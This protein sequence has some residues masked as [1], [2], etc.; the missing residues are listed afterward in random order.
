MVIPTMSRLRIGCSGWMYDDWRG[1]LYPDGRRRSGAGSSPTRSR[2]DTVEVNST[3]YRLAKRD[4]VAFW[5]NRTPEGFTF[6]VKASRYL[7]AY[8]TAGRHRGGFERFFAPLDLAGAKR[9]GPVLWQLPETFHRDDQ[10][11]AGW[12]A[13]LPPGMHA[14]EFR[15]PTGSPRVVDALGAPGRLDDRR[16]PG[17]AV[18]VAEATA[19]WWYVRFHFGRAGAAVTTRPPN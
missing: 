6:A 8:Q 17:T 2:F 3:F 10:R 13:G 11:L 9:L 5:V 12:I 18:S 4:R 14:I 19:S 7:H 16:P 15:E 1:G